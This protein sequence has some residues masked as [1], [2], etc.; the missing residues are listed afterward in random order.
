MIKTWKVWGAGLTV[1]YI[2]ICEGRKYTTYKKVR[3]H[4]SC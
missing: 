2:D 1:L 3:S 4:C